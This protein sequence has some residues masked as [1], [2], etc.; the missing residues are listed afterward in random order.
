MEE[1]AR[2]GLDVVSSTRRPCRDRGARAGPAHPARAA[3]PPP[4]AVHRHAHQRHRR[5]RHRRGP[6][7]GGRARRR[8]AALRALRRGPHDRRGDGPPVARVGPP[9]AAAD[10]AER[11]RVG[12]G[13]VAEAAFRAARRHPPF[14]RAMAR[15]MI[16]GH[17]Y[18][19]SRAGTSSACATRRSRTR[20]AAR[21]SGRAPRAS[22]GPEAGRRAGQI[23]RVSQRSA[24]HR[25]RNGPSPAPLRSRIS[26]IRPS[27][28]ARSSSGSA[29]ITLNDANHASIPS[30][31]RRPRTRSR[32]GGRARS[33]DGARPPRRGAPR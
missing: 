25:R 24:R 6:P 20:C 21:S 15:T 17:A 27:I 1:A 12:G 32:R 23:R 29:P 33:P 10:R 11:G 2:T 16:H 22:S 7:A 8:R 28:S 9:R 5:R 26:A 30:R 31:S 14:C 4:A 3:R 13:V 19:G 18:D